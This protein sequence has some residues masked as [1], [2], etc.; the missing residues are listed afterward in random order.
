MYA[1]ALCLWMGQ[2]PI[3]YTTWEKI[4]IRVHIGLFTPKSH[5]LKFYPLIPQNVT[6]FGNR[7]AADVIS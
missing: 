6:L 3:Q 4:L 2:Q 5:M 7:A 1:P